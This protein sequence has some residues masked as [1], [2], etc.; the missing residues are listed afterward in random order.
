MG[1]RVNPAGDY[2]GTTGVDH[3][4]ALEVQTDLLDLLALDQDVCLVGP[5][6]GDH[7]PALDHFCAHA[8]CL[9]QLN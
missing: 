4:V 2:V 7:R 9:F 1:V 3:F 5:V 8:L 6:S